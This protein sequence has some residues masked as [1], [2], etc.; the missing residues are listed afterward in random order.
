MTDI[1][2]REIE[3][4]SDPN[5]PV[6]AILRRCRAWVE[7]HPRVRW[8]YRLAL[9]VLGVVVVLIGVLLIPLPGPGWLIVFLGIAILGTEFPAAHRLGLFLRRV[10]ERALSWWRARRA[11]RKQ[12]A[13]QS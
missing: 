12:S 6:R 8:A 11:A 3:T 4:G 9:G 13:Q 2:A 1:L 10:L 5:H 7:R